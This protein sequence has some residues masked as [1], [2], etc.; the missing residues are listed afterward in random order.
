MR[1]LAVVMIGTVLFLGLWCWMY[2]S[3]EDMRAE[4]LYKY[5]VGDFAGMRGT[6]SEYTA[7]S[8][9]LLLRKVKHL[10]VF[11]QEIAYIEGVAAAGLEDVGT[12]ETKFREASSS[13]RTGLAARAHYNGAEYLVKRGELDAAREKYTEALKLNPLDVQ[14]KINLELLLKKIEDRDKRGDKT[15]SG[16]DEFWSDYWLRKDPKENSVSGDASK[17]IWR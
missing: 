2:G 6:L 4:A 3:Y 15:K 16:F 13:S 17:R 9:S 10:K 7:N 1:P 14:A 12:A 5:R 8:T 11:A